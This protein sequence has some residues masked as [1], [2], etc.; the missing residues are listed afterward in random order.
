MVAQN[1]HP[2]V[3]NVLHVAMVN[4]LMEIKVVVVIVLEMQLERE[5]R[6]AIPV[7]LDN[8]LVLAV[9]AVLIVQQ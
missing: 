2:V 6:V 3:Y 1:F 9:P 4:S 8:N 7:P 5:V